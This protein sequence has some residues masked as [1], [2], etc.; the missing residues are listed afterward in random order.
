MKIKIKKISVTE[1]FGIGALVVF[2]LVSLLSTTFY[3]RYVSGIFYNV[4][5]IVSISLLMIKELISEKFNFQN[6]ISM[7]GIIF[8]YIL[9]GS[10]TGFL[11]TLAVTVFFVF[12]LRDV[13]FRRVVETSLFMTTIV[14]IFV[15]LSSKLGYILDYVEVSPERIRHYLGFRY[16]LFP[17]TVLLNIVAMTLFLT[18]HRISYK[19]LFFLLLATIWIYQQTD[20]RLAFVSSLVLIGINLLMKWFPSILESNDFILKS[21]QLS[22]LVNALISY[23]IA[24]IYLTFSNPYL[25]DFFKNIN[26]FLGGR[27]YYANRSLEIY[28]YNLFGQKINWVGNGLNANGFKSLSEY[29][30]VDNL[31]IQILQRYGLVILLI[32]LIILTATLNHLLRKK[33]Y[34]LS[35]ILIVLSF[36]AMID[37]LIINLH[38]NIFLILI[39]TLMNQNQ[40]AFE[41]NLQLDNG[42]K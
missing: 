12:A 10:V 40:S 34:V 14:L 18:Q 2:L 37:D 31:Y 16:S 5:M 30:Y 11:S 36:H 25:N 13:P 33:E 9:V 35:L 17:S 15:V 28:G 3:A 6:I 7:L 20:S 27:I 1:A 24:K 4:S 26:H 19:C 8:V 32:L 41:E 23:W 21:F 22:Y 38:Y 29:L 42:E 39:G